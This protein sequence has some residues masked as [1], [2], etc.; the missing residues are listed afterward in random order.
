ML[1]D[2]LCYAVFCCVVSQVRT[3]V[4]EDGVLRALGN[5][6]DPRHMAAIHARLT[7][8]SERAGAKG[9]K[10]VDQE[11]AL[12]VAMEEW[13]LMQERQAAVSVFSVVEP[14][15]PSCKGLVLCFCLR[16][17]SEPCTT[18]QGRCFVAALT[19]FLCHPVPLPYPSDAKESLL[20]C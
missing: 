10:Y 3:R 13:R 11:R 20:C 9:H 1:H 17:F 19:A 4:A 8:S 14:M 6:L 5:D 18:E 15:S 2:L 12:T 7:A 16:G